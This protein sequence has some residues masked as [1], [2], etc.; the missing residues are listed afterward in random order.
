MFWK[1]YFPI[2]Q[3]WQRTNKNMNNHGMMKSNTDTQNSISSVYPNEIWFSARTIG[4]NLSASNWNRLLSAVSR[5]RVR[6]RG[7]CGAIKIG[8]RSWLSVYRLCVFFWLPENRLFSLNTQKN[9]QKRGIIK[10]K[11]FFGLYIQ[12]FH[13]VL[14]YRITSTLAGTH[15]KGSHR[16]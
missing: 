7:N 6:V 8:A 4:P 2:P 14:S 16:H 12:P 13:L 15:F 9:L 11:A 5:S 1:S 3:T 10:S